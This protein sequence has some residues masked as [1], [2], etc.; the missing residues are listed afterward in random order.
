VCSAAGA[1]LLSSGH[2]VLSFLAGL[3][4]ALILL[5]DSCGFSPLDWL[6]LKEARSVTVIPGTPSQKERKA[7]FLAFPLRCH[8]TGY[9]Y[10]SGKA[11]IRRAAMP[12]GILLSFLIPVIASG[13]ML[14]FLPLLPAA[15]IPAGVVLLALAADAAFR[16]NPGRQA[17]NLAPESIHEWI[18]NHASE[19]RPFVLL[20]PG[21]VEE[22]KFFLAKYRHPVFR[23]EG[24]FIEFA[25][26]N[27]GP[28]AISAAEGGFPLPYR[29]DSALLSR[30]WNAARHCGIHNPR[31]H[32]LRVKSGGLASMARGFKAI[33]VFRMDASSD[34][35]ASFP[36]E[37][38]DAWIEE[39][40]KRTEI[41]ADI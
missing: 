40:V 3:A 36:R 5:L 29:V 11:V 7:L 25:E 15:M 33:T 23:G 41:P 19:F 9:G 37:T 6:G 39:M 10:F 16:G 21:D 30:V 32:V 18:K 28:A 34:E 8:F 12:I 20:Y 35:H 27:T 13:T 4:G 1:F 14:H 2:A 31:M 17:R 38:A 26:G 24:I 22:V